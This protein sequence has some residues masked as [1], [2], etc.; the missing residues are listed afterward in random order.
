MVMGRLR[1]SR[2]RR[3]ER[4]RAFIDGELQSSFRASMDPTVI[5]KNPGQFRL[6]AAFV[7][8]IYVIRPRE[9][10]GTRRGTNCRPFSSETGL[11]IERRHKP[12]TRADGREG[13]PHPEHRSAPHAARDLPRSA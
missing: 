6:A 11:M 5:A 1:E 3:D 8:V 13:T 10:S 12:V 7:A 9:R 4:R 2:P